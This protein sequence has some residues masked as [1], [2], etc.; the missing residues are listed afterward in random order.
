[1][2]DETETEIQ[3]VL[4]AAFEAMAGRYAKLVRWLILGWA[5]SLVGL[6]AVAA[7]AL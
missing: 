1:M 5:A 6:C 7:W 2:N 3:T 4:A